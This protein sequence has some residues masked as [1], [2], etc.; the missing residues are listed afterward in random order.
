MQNYTP[1]ANNF[2]TTVA[3]PQDGV[4]KRNVSSVRPGIEAALDRSAVLAKR[5][6]EVFQYVVTS[7]NTTI[8]TFTTTSYVNSGS[9][10]VEV[11]GG[12][13][14]QAPVTG[15]VLLIDAC[16][17]AAVPGGA[18]NGLLRLQAEENLGAAVEIPGCRRFLPNGSAERQ[19]A[20]TARHVITTGGNCGIRLAGK[21]TA[22][23]SS[24]LTTGSWN[25]RVTLLR[26]A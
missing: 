16:G 25:L 12:A 21:L 6:P 23:G 11:D 2:P 14:G 8:D 19:I 1:N 18:A 4:D 7:D 20:F 24:L 10:Y 22:G 5:V 13:F 3:L 15:D 9:I 26:K 17:N